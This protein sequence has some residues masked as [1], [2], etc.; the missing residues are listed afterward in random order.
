[1]NNKYTKKKTCVT[2][3]DVEE[4]NTEEERKNVDVLYAG[5]S[6]IRHPLHHLPTATL[7]KQN[8]V[9]TS[10]WR[11]AERQEGRRGGKLGNQM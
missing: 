3:K 10:W 7:K 6:L 5:P 1:M 11:G 8:S 9:L 2:V 4:V